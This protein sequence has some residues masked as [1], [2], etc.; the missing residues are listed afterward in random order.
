M[1]GM[2][3]KRTESLAW[4]SSRLARDAA[5]SLMHPAAERHHPARRGWAP[6]TDLRVNPQFP[7]ERSEES[8][9]APDPGQAGPGCLAGNHGAPE[10]SKCGWGSAPAGAEWERPPLHPK[11]SPELRHHLLRLRRCHCG[12]LA[13]R[14]RKKRLAVVGG[15]AGSGCLASPLCATSP[16]SPLASPARTWWGPGQDPNSFLGP[17]GEDTARVISG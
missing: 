12:L 7:F 6:L 5:D 2:R 15:F 8:R 13:S 11:W 4:A 9:W 10:R 16:S 14:L 17:I 3:R 1:L